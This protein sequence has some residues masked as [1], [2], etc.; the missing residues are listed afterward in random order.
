MIDPMHKNTRCFIAVDSGAKSPTAKPV[1]KKEET[2]MR[3]NIHIPKQKKPNFQK[4]LGILRSR[5]AVPAILSAVLISFISVMSIFYTPCYEVFVQGRAV[6]ITASASLGDIV[7][8]ANSQISTISGLPGDIRSDITYVF[9]LSS[10]SN[11]SDTETIFDNILKLSSNI[12]YASVMSVDG[13]E[14]ISLPSKEAA[15]AALHDLKMSYMATPE[16]EVEILSDVTITPQ[17]VPSDQV[18]PASSALDI[19]SRSETV[20]ITYTANEDDSVWSIAKQFNLSADK[21]LQLNPSL[22][23]SVSPGDVLT[24][25]AEKPI[26]SVKTVCVETFEEDIPFDTEQT[27]DDSIYTGTTKIETEGS[28]GKQ[29]VTAEIVRIDGRETTRNVLSAETLAVPAVKMLRVGTKPIPTDVGSGSFE[30]PYVGTITS[31]FGSR[32]GGVH[33]GL[34]I[35]GNL[36]DDIR[37][38]DNGIV[39]YAGWDGD[40]GNIVRVNHNNG[41]ETWYAHLR[42]I[43]VS[44]GDVV[45]QGHIVGAL[46]STGFSTGPHLHFEVLLNGRNVDPETYYY[47]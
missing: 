29:Q 43:Y 10:K 26:I 36:G 7:D 28:P 20:D 34:D 1:K 5:A 15:Q 30:R 12:T 39:T 19:L 9:K 31:R 46:G 8:R 21:V 17:Y 27:P 41:Y 42:A 13:Q 47:G 22:V 4:L 35:S 16:T 11:L 23:G 38:A 37:V 33:N 32:W 14:V 3:R 40:F 24:L 18:I 25:P 2:F 44:P 45:E 6:G